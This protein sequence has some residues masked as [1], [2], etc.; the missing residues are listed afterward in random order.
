MYINI[1]K[2]DFLLQI[3]LLQKHC[4]EH[5]IGSQKDYVLSLN[6]VRALGIKMIGIKII[7]SEC[8]PIV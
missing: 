7:S 3:V 5:T 6:K 1:A 8:H 2:E 4:Y